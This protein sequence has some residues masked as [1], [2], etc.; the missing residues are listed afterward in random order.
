MQ[1]L[2]FII[3]SPQPYG[4]CGLCFVKPYGASALVHALRGKNLGVNL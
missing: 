2:K 1:D 4:A 3:F